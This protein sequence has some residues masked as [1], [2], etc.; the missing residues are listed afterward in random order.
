MRDAFLRYV[1]ALDPLA[2]ESVGDTGVRYSPV[3]NAQHMYLW[4]KHTLKSSE[5]K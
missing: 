3:D 1:I 2:V 5:F 4:T